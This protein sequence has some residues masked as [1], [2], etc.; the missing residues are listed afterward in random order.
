VRLHHPPESSFGQFNHPIIM[1]DEIEA[2]VEANA[3][4]RGR[5]NSWFT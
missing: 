5:R 4:Q 2:G 1:D 3:V